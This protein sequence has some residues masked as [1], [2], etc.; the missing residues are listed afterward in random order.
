M[1]SPAQS[2]RYL[3]GL[4]GLRGWAALLVF[5]YHLR[6]ALRFS[7]RGSIGEALNRTFLSFD[8]GVCLFFVLSGFLLSRPMW[9][10]VL[11]GEGL[12]SL[13][14]QTYFIRR[15]ARI[16]PAYYL[17]LICFFLFDPNSYSAKGALGTL[18]HFLC[19]QTFFDDFYT[20]QNPVLWTI[21]IEF[22]FYLL[23]PL[24]MWAAARGFRYGRLPGAMTVLC[25]VVFLGGTGYE[26][27]ARQVFTNFPGGMLNWSADGPAVTQS[28]FYFLKW[29]L[30]GI[31]TAGLH[32]RFVISKEQSPDA[33]RSS[34]GQPLNWEWLFL[35][36]AVSAVVLL[37]RSSEGEWRSISLWGWPLNVVIVALLVVSI[38]HS[39]LG[40]KLFENRLSI[41]FGEISYSI[42]LWH[43][44]LQKALA[45]GV[46]TR[47]QSTGEFLWWGSLLALCLTIL[48]ATFSY[49]LVERPA[50]RKG[51]QLESFAA[52]NQEIGKML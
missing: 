45:T 39:R 35:A 13:N 34:I 12:A 18:S 7:E 48:I 50:I 20:M 21:A 8:F 31:L 11:S 15:F 16:L 37:M 2:S 51:H 29:F 46:A 47:L 17:V 49:L 10:A 40:N 42:Y 44:P 5:L 3:P 24:L 26:Y 9:R 25:G 36:A 19:V 32:E 6:W 38:P 1:S 22:Q 23:L 43:Y 14:W 41:F 28:V 33:N 52:L 30:P 27:V 4:T